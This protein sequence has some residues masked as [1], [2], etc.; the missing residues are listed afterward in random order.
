M[1][2]RE[3]C[4]EYVD[5]A[6]EQEGGLFA[7][8]SE[9][10][11]FQIETPKATIRLS[12]GRLHQVPMRDPTDLFDLPDHMTWQM[13]MGI[14]HSGITRAARGILGETFVPTQDANGDRIMSGMES[15]RG[16]QEDCKF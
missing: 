12:H 4:I 7:H 6:R 5:H 2:N 11:T 16:K 15:I 10:A 9:H 13:N 1:T 14:D 3:E 8:Q